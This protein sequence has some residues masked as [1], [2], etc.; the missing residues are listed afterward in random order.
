MC[1]ISACLVSLASPAAEVIKWTDVMTA[2]SSLALAATAVIAGVAALYQLYL[3]RQTWRIKNTFSLV[4]GYA[5]RSSQG[6][7]P[8]EARAALRDLHGLDVLDQT[9]G[10]P[11][12]DAVI[13]RLIQ[14]IRD[15]V[16]L[17]TYFDEADDL[18][19][20][21][22]IDRSFF[23]S[24]LSKTIREGA[25]TLREF[26]PLVPPSVRNP[27]LIE[28]LETMVDACETGKGHEG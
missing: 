5:L 22:L 4:K 12:A 19:R 9:P 13:E 17:Q 1:F 26:A 11:E 24:R 6:L 10:S 15:Y 3:F 8:M 23:L 20:R 28:R 18:Y 27:K 21:K 16:I 7:S 2:E 14:A 25:E